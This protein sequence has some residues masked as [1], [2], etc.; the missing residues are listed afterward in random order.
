MNARTETQL[1][2]QI[3]KAV[4]AK[5]PKIWVLK[6]HGGGYQRAGVPDLLLCLRGRLIALE[7]K[8]PKPG[9]TTERILRRVSAR[10][11]VELDSLH[12]AEAEAHV[13]WTVDQAMRIL[14]KVEESI[15][16]CDLHCSLICN[17]LKI[18][19]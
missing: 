4:K 7:V 6:V 10:Q 9:E 1:T 19:T 13:V 18:T 5:Y 15:R 8:H 3:V 14:A 11:H 12:Q 2:G 17:T 16:R